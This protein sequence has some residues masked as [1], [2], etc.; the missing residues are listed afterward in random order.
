MLV[1][2][3]LDM[4]I[5]FVGSHGKYVGISFF[6]TSSANMKSRYKWALR[7]DLRDNVPSQIDKENNPQLWKEKFVENSLWYRKINPDDLEARW[8]RMIATRSYKFPQGGFRMGILKT[9]LHIATKPSHL[10]IVQQGLTI[11]QHRD[12]NLVFE[13]EIATLMSKAAV[14]IGVPEIALTFIQM[15]WLKF[16]PSQRAIKILLD[17]YAEDAERCFLDRFV[18]GEP[19]LLPPQQ[20]KEKNEKEEEDPDAKAKAEAKHIDLWL[21]KFTDTYRE[22]RS[23]RHEWKPSNDSYSSVIRFYAAVGDVNAAIQLHDALKGPF[24]DKA[25]RN[26]MLALVHQGRASEAIKY[27]LAEGYP[28]STLQGL[29]AANL[30]LKDPSNTLA[31]LKELPSLDLS[32]VQSHFGVPERKQFIKHIIKTLAAEGPTQVPA[33]V[34]EYVKGF[35]E[36]PEG[37][38]D[39]KVMGEG[40][41]D[42]KDNKKEALQ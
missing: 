39:S 36:M 30:A 3:H 13:S 32:V 17:K 25:L 33:E 34:M 11:M 31:I 21:S 28:N 18:V 7:P 22:L 20:A 40:E 23:D 2:R 37:Q 41:G 38:V 6:H 26:I 14:R 16:W 4:F 9:M 8:T 19:P 12:Q 1:N 24:S 5:R 29:V 15:P 10:R 42:V 27:K 35:P